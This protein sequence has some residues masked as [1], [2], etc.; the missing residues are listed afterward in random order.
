[1]ELTLRNYQF[2]TGK[3]NKEQQRYTL[4]V[5][6]NKYLTHYFQVMLFHRELVPQFRP[7]R[8]EFRKYLP[9]VLKNPRICKMKKIAILLMFVHKKMSYKLCLRLFPECILGNDG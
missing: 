4:E 9:D 6:A 7:Y 1:M 2:F 5:Y 3:R 8:D